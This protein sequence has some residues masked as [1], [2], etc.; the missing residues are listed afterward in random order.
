MTL[1]AMTMKLTDL[2]ID[3]QGRDIALPYFFLDV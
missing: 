2:D 3:L 1:F